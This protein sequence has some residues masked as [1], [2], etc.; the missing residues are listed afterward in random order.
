MVRSVSEHYRRIGSPRLCVRLLSP[1]PPHVVATTHHAPE[2]RSC[3][4]SV[5]IER[6]FLVVSERD[7]DGVILG[8]R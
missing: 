1:L 2:C 3:L 6:T 4:S 5:G 7:M 8:T